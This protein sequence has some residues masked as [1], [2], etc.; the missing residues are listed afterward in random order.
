MRSPRTRSAA[1]G[2]L[3]VGALAC[4]AAGCGTS[5]AATTVARQAG[6]HT[7]SPTPS[8]AE[9]RCANAHVRIVHPTVGPGTPPRVLSS[10]LGVLREPA[11]T[12]ATLPSKFEPI[13]FSR[14]W[15]GSTRLLATS[16]S[17]RYWLVAGTDTQK[18]PPAC[19]KAES[20]AQRRHTLALKRQQRIGAV[21]VVASDQAT[22]V[23]ADVLVAP[24]IRAGSGV[25]AGPVLRQAEPAGQLTRATTAYGLV[26]DG[27]DKVTLTAPNGRAFTAHVSH[28][29]IEMPVR[30]DWTRHETKHYV[31]L[32]E[33]FTMRWT[34]ALGATVKTT[35][36]HAGFERARTP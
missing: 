20:P 14:I 10:I 18:V 32:S 35:K 29:F 36:V 27:V 6:S 23:D 17:T 16:G 2:A 22:P 15:R 1:V 7:K 11:A 4:A 26:P 8:R 34:S 12:A 5:S 21:A 28:N 9:R 13:G 33:T 24:Q 30:Y 19:L 3:A 25:T 31:V